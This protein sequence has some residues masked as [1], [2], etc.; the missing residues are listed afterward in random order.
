[1]T[2]F[3]MVFYQSF[4]YISHD[5]S[6]IHTNYKMLAYQYY[7]Y[8]Q[9]SNIIYIQ[10]M[11]MYFNIQ[12]I[13]NIAILMYLGRNM[14]SISHILPPYIIFIQSKLSDVKCYITIL[15]SC[16]IFILQEYDL[17]HFIKEKFGLILREKKVSNC[18]FF[19][20]KYRMLIIEMEYY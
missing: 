3:L 15:N 20:I 6:V 8:L 13:I 17:N 4:Y 2:T 9:L 11:Y 19:S 12:I 18:N 14:T 1:M 5:C 16:S 10:Y 7:I